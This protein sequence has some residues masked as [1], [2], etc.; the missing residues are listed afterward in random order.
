M[1]K[2][3][4][5]QEAVQAIHS[6]DR[7]VLAHSVGEPQALVNAM[8]D[9][10][11]AYQN[12][13][14]LHMLALGP[15]KYTQPQYA[16]HFWHNSLFAGPGSRAAVNEGR[17]DYT[18]NLFGESPR[19]FYEG[20][21]PIDVALITLSPP[22]ERGYCSYGVTV[23]YTKCITETAKLVIAQI[24][25]CMPRTYGDTLVHI[26]DIDL[27]VRCDEPLFRRPILPSGEVE[28]KIGA[29]C[30]SLIDDGSTIQLGI[31][32]IPDAILSFLD[33]KNDLGVHS[34]MLCDGALRLLKQG[35]INNSRKNI[36]KGVSVVTYLYGQ[37][38]LYEYARLN[39]KLQIFPVDYV[40][41]PRIIGQNDNV[42]SVNSALSVDLIG[43]VA[44]DSISAGTIFS[45]AGGFVDFVRGASFSKGGKSIIAMPS[46]AMK[47]KASRIVE[48]FDAGRPITLSRFET[49]YVVT[50]YG[51]AN[52][53]GRTLRQRARDLIA[54][55]HPDFRDGLK[56]AYE[57]K[58]RE[59]F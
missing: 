11:Q 32:S 7:V 43:Q 30:A 37:D 48:Q 38:E 25:D 51:I 21:L 40:N 22:D 55:A 8:L 23:D 9:N 56:E 19:L 41:D 3:V 44:A 6:G 52:L 54:I 16:G 57:R 34:E 15:C 12:V 49:H 45:G 17:A 28:R 10:Y 58:F 47:G 59:A 31:G 26:D 46:T 5:A 2:F 42:V 18:P 13:E 20:I 33:E 53:R 29:H 24:N 35:N 4:T 36:N 27:A 50:E 39:P 1:A 14:V